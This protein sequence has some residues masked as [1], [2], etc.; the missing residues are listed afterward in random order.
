MN[1]DERLKKLN[2]IAVN[3]NTSVNDLRREWL[4]EMYDLGCLTH[5]RYHLIMSWIEAEEAVE[6]LDYQI[7][8]Y[9]EMIF[10][11]Q[12]NDSLDFNEDSYDFP[13]SQKCLEIASKLTDN[14]N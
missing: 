1:S 7:L 13:P 12:G 3:G 6:S 4:G 11:D 14:S 10:P 9:H 2:A 8:E 5:E